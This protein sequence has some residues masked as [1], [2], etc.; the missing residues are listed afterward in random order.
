LGVLGQQGLEHRRHPMG[1]QGRVQHL[2]LAG[3]VQVLV[4]DVPALPGIAADMAEG[5]VRGH[6]VEAV[7][8]RLRQRL[9][10][11]GPDREVQSGRVIIGRVEPFAADTDDVGQ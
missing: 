2:P 7:G 4:R 5:E 9:R 1:S 6:P 10:I 11:A 8:R 3:I